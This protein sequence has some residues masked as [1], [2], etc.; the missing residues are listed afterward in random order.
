MPKIVPEYEFPK[1]SGGP[2]SPFNDFLDGQTYRFAPDELPHP[3]AKKSAQAFKALAHRRGLKPHTS[4]EEDG[5]LVVAAT[6]KED[7][8]AEAS[9]G[10]PSAR[11]ARRRASATA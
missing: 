1:R 4:V 8:E 5:S 6:P 11:T 7:A 9:N 3:D 10:S 2:R